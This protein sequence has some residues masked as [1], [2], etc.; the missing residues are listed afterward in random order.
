MFEEGKYIAEE[1]E[2]AG[3][4]NRTA[5]DTIFLNVFTPI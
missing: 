4:G 3:G 2:E 1:Q 5:S